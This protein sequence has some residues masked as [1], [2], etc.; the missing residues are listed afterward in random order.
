[1][2]RQVRIAAL[3]A[4]LPL[5]ACTVV[6]NVTYHRLSDRPRSDSWVPYRLTDT[7]IA[8]GLAGDK[9]PVDLSRSAVICTSRGCKRCP[10]SGCGIDKASIAARANQPYVTLAAIGTP[11]DDDREVL[12]I[13]PK[14][15]NLV[16]T[17]LAPTYYPGSLRLKALDVEAKDHKMEIIN[18]LGAI[19]TGAVGLVADESRAG[20]KEEQGV[21]L[22]LPILIDLPL[23]RKAATA[24]DFD[25]PNADWTYQFEFKDKDPAAV[26]FLARAD[27]GQVHGAIVASTCR[28]ARIMLATGAF[29]LPSLGVT[30]ADP[31]WLTVVPF[32][33]KGTIAFQPL[34]GVDVQNSQVVTVATDALAEGFFKQV[35]AVRAAAK[36]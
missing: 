8:I 16:S 34:C 3:L 30:V 1:M 24:T 15:R 23:A 20:E 29:T 36:K 22:D 21:E 31:E 7:S 11:I 5:A 32:P 4:L 12:A 18:T 35:A 28:P 6:P 26:G 14:S 13:E 33:G 25:D 19:A 9:V 2:S 17:H 10:D 27:R